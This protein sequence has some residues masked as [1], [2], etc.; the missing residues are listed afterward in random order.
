MC[1]H[2]RAGGTG[3]KYN[4]AAAFSDYIEPLLIGRGC[5]G[6]DKIRRS[7]CQPT[8]LATPS[9]TN[10]HTTPPYLPKHT[11]YGYGCH[12]EGDSYGSTAFELLVLEGVFATVSNKYQR[13]MSCFEPVIQDILRFANAACTFTIIIL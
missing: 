10:T 5:S 7:A 11:N 13:R 3:G 2:K 4:I 8:D 9:P 1:A 12:Q 6:L